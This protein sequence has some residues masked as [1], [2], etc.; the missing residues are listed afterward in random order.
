LSVLGGHGPRVGHID[1][2]YGR[3]AFGTPILMEF[4]NQRICIPF[5]RSEDDSPGAQFIHSGLAEALSLT[6]REWDVKVDV[7]TFNE[8]HHKSLGIFTMQGPKLYFSQK[9]LEKLPGR[10]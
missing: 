5:R 8:P 4:L 6:F 7:C 9:K 3:R 1:K 2:E 10:D